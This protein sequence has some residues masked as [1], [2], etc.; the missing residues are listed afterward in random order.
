MATL[1]LDKIPTHFVKSCVALLSCFI[2]PV[3]PQ[4]CLF[5]L[6]AN[7]QLTTNLHICRQY[8]HRN[9]QACAHTNLIFGHVLSLAV[10]APSQTIQS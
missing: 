8:L 5:S 6:K 1:H 2:L 9:P 3:I 10:V 7:V 4:L